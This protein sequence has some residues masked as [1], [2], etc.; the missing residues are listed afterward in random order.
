MKSQISVFISTLALAAASSPHALAAAEARAPTANDE[1]QA[2]SE[3]Q[4]FGGDG[5]VWIR[6]DPNAYLAGPI[7]AFRICAGDKIDSI[8][9]RYGVDDPERDRKAVWG[10]KFGGG[11]GDCGDTW[12]LNGR[13]INAIR[14]RHGDVIDGLEFELSGA[15]NKKFGG[16]GGVESLSTAK[17]GGALA[18]IEARAGDYVDRI[19]LVY[20][21]PYYI[22]NVTL[23][24]DKISDAVKNA[25]LV[26]LSRQCVINNTDRLRSPG[27]TVS[28]EKTVAE[29]LRFGLTTNWGISQT[30]SYGGEASPVSGETTINVGQEISQ[31]EEKSESKTQRLELTVPAETDPHSGLLV[32]FNTKK[33]D[34]DIPFTYDIVHYKGSKRNEVKREKY[35]GTYRAV[36]YTDVEYEYDDSITSCPSGSKKLTDDG[37]LATPPAPAGVES[38]SAPS[39]GS[40]TTSSPPVQPTSAENFT[41][42]STTT[43]TAQSAQQSS[44]AYPPASEPAAG[45][46]VTCV[47]ATN[48]ESDTVFRYGDDGLWRE[49]SA[50]ES[51]T[52]F[53]FEEIDRDK[54][55]VNLLDIDRG[56]LIE[57]DLARGQISY[58]PDAT[59]EP[60]DIYSITRVESR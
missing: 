14:V 24:E 10:K 17:N 6:E 15:A 23:D 47:Y 34:L 42:G 60:F 41:A 4:E 38:T 32:T 36:R 2:D 33:I 40:P 26:E 21:L 43:S 49:L 1:F 59:S 29:S 5:G 53:T 22:D 57:L 44:T 3:A 13:K 56:V 30:I 12:E 52:R 25:R 9:V 51:E 55:S 35:K 31:E 37:V 7:T 39:T 18:Y 19:R 50:D 28:E 58:A 48:G 45:N 8:Q 16:N 20:G 11:G 27:A 54:D 46:R